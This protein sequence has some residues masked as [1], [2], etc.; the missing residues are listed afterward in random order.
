M[1]DSTNLSTRQLGGYKV[2]TNGAYFVTLNSVMLI[3]SQAALKN[4]N[5]SLEA[6]ERSAQI[7]DEVEHS[8]S[9]QH[10]SYDDGKDETRVNAGYKAALKSV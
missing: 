7:L 2:R 9:E 4:P 5:V 1:A 10:V 8:Q 6:K 3:Q